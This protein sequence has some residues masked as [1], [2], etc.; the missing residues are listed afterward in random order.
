MKSPTKKYFLSRPRGSLLILTVWLLVILSLFT[1][2]VG[3]AARQ[4]ITV[5]KGLENRDTLRAT[6]E[7]GVYRA[8]DLINK[9]SDKTRLPDSINQAWSN[10]P[11]D[12]QNI[13]MGGSFFSVAKYFSGR[14]NQR[15]QK[16]EQALYGLVDEDS[17]INLNTVTSAQVLQRFF[18]GAGHVSSEKA[19]EIAESLLDW[20]DEDDFS[21]AQGAENR[22][23]GL[24]NPPYKAKNKKL[25]T[26]EE[27]LFVRGMT[28]GI[29][30][31]IKPYVTIHS[32]GKININTASEPVLDAMG[33]S[34]SLVRKIVSY[35]KGPDQVLGTSD[36]GVFTDLETVLPVL[37]SFSFLDNNEKAILDHLTAAKEIDIASDYFWV[38]SVAYFQQQKA[39]LIVQ[40]VIQRYGKIVSWHEEYFTR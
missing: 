25:D 16:E 27:L 3:Y 31:D 10:S 24:L 21:Y 23:Y 14:G 39:A 5:L 29:F 35:R 15:Y 17:K 19:Q 32:T 7:A 34:P 4:K 30:E 1:L 33:F 37:D 8:M 20:I 13:P 22:Y 36:D 38:Q 11:G 9:K 2:A 28:P 18:Q 26:L 12:F 40:C 6:V